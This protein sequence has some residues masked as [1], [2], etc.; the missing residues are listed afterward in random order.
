MSQ[1]LHSE[2][3]DLRAELHS[4]KVD[5]IKCMFVCWFTYWIATVIPIAGIL[6]YTR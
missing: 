6:L 3:Q 5:L 1:D 2:F 4:I